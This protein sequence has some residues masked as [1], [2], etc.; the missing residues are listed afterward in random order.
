MNN[1]GSVLSNKAGKVTARY[2]MCPPK[3]GYALS[4]T[5]ESSGIIYVGTVTR[6]YVG[7]KLLFML[8]HPEGDVGSVNANSED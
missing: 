1:K 2:R 3:V 4:F 5:D 6:V 8:L 7:A